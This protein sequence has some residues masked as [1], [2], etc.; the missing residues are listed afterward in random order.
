MDK[1]DLRRFQ[2]STECQGWVQVLVAEIALN[3]SGMID[4]EFKGTLTIIDEKTGL[5]EDVQCHEAATLRAAF[6]QDITLTFSEEFFH[7]RLHFEDK[8]IG[9]GEYDDLL[10]IKKRLI[11]YLNKHNPCC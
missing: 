7:Y 1:I 5:P 9:V 6:V 11:A 8:L 2:G 4:L 10:P 3:D